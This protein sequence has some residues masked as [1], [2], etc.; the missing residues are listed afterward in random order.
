MI[1]RTLVPTDVRPFTDNG[2]KKP[3]RRLTTYMDDRTV[4][5]SDLSDAP[6]LTGKTN[7]PEHLPLDVLIERSLVPRGLGVKPFQ[8]FL[9][10]SEFA[11]LAILDQRVVV[12]AYVEPPEQR[13]IDKF[14]Q[15]P[16][17]TAELR[18]IVSP[19]I[20]NTG[21]ANLLVEP[22]DRRD[23]KWDAITRVISV[24]AHIAF[25][26]FLIFLPKIFPT[27]VPTREETEIASKELGVVYLPPDEGAVSKRP[28][29][30]PGPV[31]KITPKTLAKVAPPRPEEHRIEPPP[32]ASE[33]PPLDLPAAP[34]PKVNT[35]PTPNTAPTQPPPPEPSK[36]M[37]ILPPT[38]PGHLNLGIPN[39]SP[40]RAM[41]E[42]LA[43]A[44]RHAPSGGTYTS[45]G[46]VSGGGG[47]G[48][49]HG[50][51]GGGGAQAG[52]G[53]TILTPTE[54]VDFQSYINRLLAKLKQNWI[55][56]MPESFYLGDKG[57]VAISFRINRDGSFPGESLSLDR[58]SGKEP[59]DTA[60][61]SAIRAT[62][63]FEPLPPQF[64]G[65]YIDLR[66]G[67][68]YN[69]RPDGATQ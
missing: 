4:V 49:G 41:Q 46:T 58:T 17:M 60:A 26:I 35:S 48:G 1:P 40:G 34:T 28:S 53:V 18:E 11:P 57:I 2:D 42:D 23:A 39:A 5:P 65:P 50:G 68:Y 66:I 25:I 55:T 15:P 9:P 63:P 14:D 20:F 67:F 54:G 64:K 33:R 69:I 21:E 47:T 12:P 56:V 61:A 37:P 10:P 52:N 22:E 45:E 38:T 7:I 8:Q 44:A 51:R 27:H 3:P 36:L 43:D 29:P 19:D 13:E 62:S 16:Q 31:V 24:A 6:P 32:V 59:L 30:P